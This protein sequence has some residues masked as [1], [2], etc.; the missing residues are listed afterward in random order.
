M[1]A[2]SRLRGFTKNPALVGKLLGMVFLLAIPLLFLPN[3]VF[4]WTVYLT[5]ALFALS[6]DLVWGY[7]GLLTL[8]HAAFF[9]AGAY[10]VAK[11]LEL[12]PAIPDIA[13]LFGLVPLF[14]G[15]LAFLIGWF[16]FSAD[17]SG[18]YFAITTLI[19]AIVFES[20]AGEFV[21][22]LGGFNGLYGFPSLEIAGTEPETIPLYYLTL[23]VLIGFF[24]LSQWIVNS[25]FGRQLRGIRQDMER[26]GMFGYNTELARLL[27]FTL[28]GAMAGIAGGLYAS[29]N[30][31]ISPPLLG[32][33][34]STQVVIWVAVGG[35]GTLTGAILGAILIQYLNS[36]LSDVLLNYW[37]VVL[38]LV[39]IAV[40]IVAPRGIVGM[41][42][43]F[44]GRFGP[45]S[46]STAAATGEVDT[47][48]GEMH[49]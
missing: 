14:C 44:F 19:V 40:V 16:L 29:V 11:V 10:L 15:L 25:A 32:F 47:D 21:S 43:D 49:E 17:V 28:S 46:D 27:I 36:S 48:G 34:L 9:G 39:F 2:T 42:E 8:G 26:T 12:Y 5:F 3:D 20:V 33:V 1:A 13:V 7:T 23:A 22:F 24:L 30:G 37:N 35:R 38:A 41:L 4:T 18:A 45:D 6:I 31:F